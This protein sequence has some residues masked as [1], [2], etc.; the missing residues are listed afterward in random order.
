MRPESSARARHRAA[1]SGPHRR[2]RIH[3]AAQAIH[4]CAGFKSTP[5]QA[6]RHPVPRTRVAGKTSAKPRPRFRGIPQALR[7]CRGI[8]WLEVTGVFFFLPVLVFTPTL[9]RTR[10]S[11]LHGPEPQDFR[12]VRNCSRPVF[13]TSESVPSGAPASDRTTFTVEAYEWEVRASVKVR[14]Q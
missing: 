9:W 7:S 8:L 4:L 11:F 10:A 2:P 13:S 6:R 1:R 3:A 12:R 5:K 14:A